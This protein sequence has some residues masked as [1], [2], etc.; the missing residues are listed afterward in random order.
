MP[1]TYAQISL[2]LGRGQG[3]GEDR[4]LVSRGSKTR[5][6]PLHR[7]FVD[8]C[9]QI[10]FPP[11]R[12]LALASAVFMV[13]FLI[14]CTPEQPS[15]APAPTEN[16][17]PTQEP[18]P[19][20]P[21]K[22]GSEPPVTAPEPTDN[23]EPT[24]APSPTTPSRGGSEP[25]RQSE[26]EQLSQFVS[27]CEEESRFRRGQ[28][29]YP[30][31]LR[32]RMG[33]AVTFAAAVDVRDN[34]LPPEKVIDTDDPGSDP[35]YVQCV[36]GARLVSVGGGIDV[37]VADSSDGGWKYQEFTPKGELKWAWSVTA[38]SPGDQELRLELRPAARESQLIRNANTSA[39]YVTR[40]TVD[41]SLIGRSWYWLQTEGNLLK[42]IF[43]SLSAAVL[44]ILA[45]SAKVRE[46]LVKV[47]G[48]HPESKTSRSRGGDQVGGIPTKKPKKTTNSKTRAQGKRGQDTTSQRRGGRT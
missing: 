1:E 7:Y 10:A 34:P 5:L 48:R 25:P 11:A 36:V 39:S 46:G 37:D 4:E 24:Q 27:S 2:S 23:A 19:T 16:A 29:D 38:R 22:G 15:T 21:S 3:V 44:A 18:N 17:E 20:A 40:V 8:Q 47:I 31:T 13:A 9:C 12:I 6:G 35:I 28:V 26:D 42:A 45:F 43:I 32:M 14:A 33:E 30:S 41:A